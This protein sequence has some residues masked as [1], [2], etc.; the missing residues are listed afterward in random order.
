MRENPTEQKRQNGGITKKQHK[1]IVKTFLLTG[2]SAWEALCLALLAFG[3]AKAALPPI[4]DLTWDIQTTI[5]AIAL[6]TRSEAA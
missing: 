2:Q 5:L 3:K 1:R 4:R 6:P